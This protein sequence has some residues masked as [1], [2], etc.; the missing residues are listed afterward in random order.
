MT[1]VHSR[2]FLHEDSLR[3]VL[4][5]WTGQI[6]ADLVTNNKCHLIIVK[7]RDQALMGFTFFAWIFL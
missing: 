5:A 2:F 4:V 3:T 6:F 7:V 1:M